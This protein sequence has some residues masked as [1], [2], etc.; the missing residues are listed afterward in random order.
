LTLLILAN[1]KDYV[2]ILFAIVV[3]EY[4]A[5]LFDLFDLFDLL[6]STAFSRVAVL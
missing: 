5:D 1:D 6:I 2:G 3:P 4:Y